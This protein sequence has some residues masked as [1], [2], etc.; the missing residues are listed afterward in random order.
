METRSVSTELEVLPTRES[1]TILNAL[2]MRVNEYSNQIREL[3]R[4]LQSIHQY[5]E[6]C[7]TSD[8]ITD[9]HKVGE[10]VTFLDKLKMVDDRLYE[11]NSSLA[12]SLRHLNTII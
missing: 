11:L 8:T 1:E 5:N 2:E 6:P 4:R 12:F 3:G 9:E 7:S 10:N